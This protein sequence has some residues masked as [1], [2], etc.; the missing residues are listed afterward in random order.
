MSSIAELIIKVSMD[1]GQFISEHQ[2]IINLSEQLA[3][4]FDKVKRLLAAMQK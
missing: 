2:H 4:K 1:D 3:V